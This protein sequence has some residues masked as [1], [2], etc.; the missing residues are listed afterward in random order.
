MQVDIRSKSNTKIKKV[1]KSVN[2]CNC[3]FYL[4]WAIAATL[5]LGYVVVE[6]NYFDRQDEQTVP[7]IEATSSLMFVTNDEM[8]VKQ[9]L[10]A[11]SQVI[12]QH[13]DSNNI[14]FRV[15]PSN[16]ETK[17]IEPWAVK[18]LD[19]GSSKAPCLILFDGSRMEIET[20]PSTVEDVLEKLK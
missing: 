14:N 18:M 7:V 20:I 11:N 2:F 15:Y 17:N 5:A 13:C 1:D 12:Q 9:K 3:T 6:T 19:E 16:A 10:V 8:S 4:I